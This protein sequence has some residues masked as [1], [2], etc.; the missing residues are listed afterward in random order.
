[1]ASV[2]INYSIDMDRFSNTCDV[3]DLIV[4]MKK[5]KLSLVYLHA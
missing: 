4:N 3:F 2:D 5:S 1:M